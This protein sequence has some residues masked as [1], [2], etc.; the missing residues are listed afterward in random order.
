M[1]KVKWTYE[2]C[3]EEA[4]KYESRALFQKCNGSAYN[5][6]IKQ[7][8]L[9]D[10]CSHMVL[11][12]K[13]N[14]YWT[15][16]RCKEE[17]SKYKTIRDMR[18]LSNKC[19]AIILYNNWQEL[20][21]R[22]DRFYRP[23]GY[24]N[25][26]EI[27]K[28]EALKYKT[29]SEFSKNN[30][31]AYKYSRENNWLDE[32][33]SHMEILGTLHKRFIYAYE[34]PDNHVY[35]G[36]TYNINRRRKAHKEKGAVFN[37]SHESKLE[38]IFKQLILEPVDLEEAQKLEKEY[39]EK[40]INKG[41]KPLNKAKTGGVGGNS[42]KWNFDTLKEEALK[43]NSRSEFEKENAS[44]YNSARIRG[45]LED[46]CKHMIF[47]H[48]P[49]GYWDFT[50]VSKEASKY[51]SRTKFRKGNSMAYKTALKNKWMD[52]VCNHM[53]SKSKD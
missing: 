13:P 9:D 22:L 8:W 25:D 38:P 7:G 19:Y 1:G 35:V 26:K 6:A 50:N 30:S 17:V 49:K 24:W 4:L 5:R 29:R 48:K 37:Y 27:C 10:I 3:K 23:E 45:I 42:L 39:L 20:L 12:H 32:I 14:G 18:S 2:A 36:L 47:L 28:T 16:D 51:S 15:Y 46:I 44:A 41:W 53:K 11:L 40:Y 21:N 31:V 43:Y 33:C 34:F 52:I